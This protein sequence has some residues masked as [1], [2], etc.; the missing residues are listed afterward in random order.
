[1]QEEQHIK[2][3]A[4]QRRVSTSAV[5]KPVPPN[6]AMWERMK[7][8]GRQPTLQPRTFFA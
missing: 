3:V 7:S 5:K 8:A 2:Y 1:M 6:T 4:T